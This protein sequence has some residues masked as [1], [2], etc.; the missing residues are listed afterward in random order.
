[1]RELGIF[2]RQ[3]REDKGMTIAE[4]SDRTKIRQAYLEAIEAGNLD[5]L[6]ED[7][8]YVRGFVRIYAKVLGIDPDQVTQML[9]QGG[10][11]EDQDQ[12]AEYVLTANGVQFWKSAGRSGGKADS[13]RCICNCDHRRHCLTITTITC[14]KRA[15]SWLDGL[16]GPIGFVGCSRSF[17]SSRQPPVYRLVV[18]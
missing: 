13:M 6:P 10:K 15:R 3:A 18:V 11:A 1:M 4:A 16:S 7:P 17:G 5:E 14:A 12:I 8:V 2:L 9:D